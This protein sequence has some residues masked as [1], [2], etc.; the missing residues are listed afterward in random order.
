MA[1]LLLAGNGSDR[2]GW[3][4]ES[5][6]RRGQ[7][8]N[9]LGQESPAVDG[10]PMSNSAAGS[11][12]D[13]SRPAQ[14]WRVG[15]HVLRQAWPW[16]RT[17]H[18]LLRHLR[19]VGFDACPQVVG[20]GFDDAGNEVLTWI[21]GDVIHPQLWPQ[22]VEAV[23]HVGHLLRQLHA[24]TAS[25]VPPPDARWMPWTLHES[26]PRSVISH[27]NVAPWNIVHRDGGPVAFVGW[28]YAGPTDRLTEIAVT[29][30]YCAQLYDDDVADRVGLPSPDVRVGWFKAFLD[31]YELPLVER[32]DLVTRIIEFAVRD[33]AAYARRQSITPESTD[34]DH[35]WPLSWPIRAADWMIRN[36]ALVQKVIES[37]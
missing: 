35:L 34:P 21:E 18:S 2:A 29:G 33:T 17:T 3:A 9:Q 8:D 26:G 28:E 19:N 16:T 10:R 37:R 30:W 1:F 5:L 13:L 23:H 22:A 15:P 6:D 20:D 11:E 25:F 27:C 7:E 31:G 24:A 32:A 4:V 12:P 14:T 36:R